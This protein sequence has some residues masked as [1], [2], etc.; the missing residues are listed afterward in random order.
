MKIEEKKQEIVEVFRMMYRRGMVNLF[1]GNISVRA[2]DRFLVTPSQQNKETMTADMILEVDGEGK[3]LK[4]L[5]EMKPSSEFKMHLEVYRLRP[6]VGACVHNHSV[7]ATAF[8]AAGQPIVSS[9]IAESNVV[10]GQIPV[11]VY[12][13][14]GTE[15]IYQSFE[16]LLPQYNVLLLENHGVLAV[17]GD[18]LHAYSFAEAAEKT[19][20]IILFTKLLGGEKPLPEEELMA[21]RG[22]GQ[23]LRSKAMEQ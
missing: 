11:A 18:L 10:F 22:Y 8:A 2:K 17:G 15:A 3:V 6:D 19:A 20:K 16:G 1:E 5:P 7:C 4:G 12:G 23:M 13:R 21:L 9:G 14:P